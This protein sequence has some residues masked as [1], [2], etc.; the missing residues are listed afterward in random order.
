[1]KTTEMTTDERIATP[2]REPGLAPGALEHD[3]RSIMMP[4]GGQLL[5]RPCG[6]R[7]EVLLDGRT[8]LGEFTRRGGVRRRGS[9]GR[10]GSE[11]WRWLRGSCSGWDF[12]LSAQG[13]TVSE[14]G[15]DRPACVLQRMRLDDGCHPACTLAQAGVAPLSTAAARFA[16][17]LARDAQL[18][19]FLALPGAP[20][21]MAQPQAAAAAA[22]PAPL[23]HP[24]A[25][26]AEVSP[27]AVLLGSETK[28][29]VRE[30]M[31]RLDEQVIG[32][33]RAKEALAT[34][35]Y[36]RELSL[37][38][39]EAERMQPQPLLLQGP[40]GC[41]KT[42]LVSQLARLDHCPFVR[43]V[44][45]DFTNEGYDGRSL[46]EIFDELL[47]AAGRMEEKQLPEPL[48]EDESLLSRQRRACETRGIIFI[49]EL[50]K[51]CPSGNDHHDAYLRG[52]QHELLNLIS[53][54][55]VK[56]PGKNADKDKQPLMMETY[57]MLF[58][59][60]GAFEDRDPDELCTELRGRLGLPV[61]M[62]GL[63]RADFMAILRHERISPLRQLQRL[64]RAAGR[65][66]IITDE[67]VAELAELAAARRH[68]GARSLYDM[69]AQ[70]Q[71]A[72]LS[73]RLQGTRL[74][75]AE[76]R[77]CVRGSGAHDPDP[78]LPAPA[79]PEVREV[80][81]HLNGR[82]H[83]QE[84][85]K[86]ALA[87]AYVTRLVCPQNAAPGTYPPQH[88]LL[89]GPTGC[90]KTSLVRSLAAFGACPLA[91]A[92]ASTFPSFGSAGTILGC[93]L[94]DLYEH[95]LRLVRGRAPELP[96]DV[97]ALD[98]ERASAV[99]LCERYGIIFLD[100]FDKLCTEAGGSRMQHELLNFVE[101]RAQPLQ[102]HAGLSLDTA[103]MLFICAG[104]FESCGLN[105]LC[106]E[107]RGRLLLQ[108]RLQALGYEDFL[109]ILS[110]P[111]SSPLAELQELLRAAGHDISLERDGVEM[112]ARLAAENSQYGGRAL[113]SICAQLQRAVMCGTLPDGRLDAGMVERALGGAARQDAD[114][115]RRRPIGFVGLRQN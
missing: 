33:Q 107:L 11:A 14:A 44:I 93:I 68:F 91:L 101:G 50:D 95:A 58:I 10:A 35:C 112:I 7:I 24:A 20:R 22:V 105:G 66:L 113:L 5:L 94:D 75:A 87:T 108:A 83:G 46:T 96:A 86:Q 65:D 26:Q 79:V 42:R 16:A 89:Q 47:A 29:R 52:M 67:A 64:A 80:I 70:L 76:V 92:D 100:E 77:A 39:G 19:A 3:C 41:G 9:G 13:L 37:G 31:A 21:P 71:Q 115:A 74:G 56:L 15:Q 40:T 25:V 53:G 43:A 103:R 18:R 57:G 59:C 28:G 34:A 23:P 51:L 32:Q 69:A 2:R 81:A 48:S 102:S 72:V 84:Q 8:M 49:D 12:V 38:L 61:R 97:T 55:R 85:A 88:V 17:A 62:K 27:P 106:R 109:A 60:A 6:P 114:Q 98:T 54:K 73:G 90:G 45:T 36:V 4:G 30:L 63:T 110:S 82:V 78:N 104:A 111:D 1:M 99:R